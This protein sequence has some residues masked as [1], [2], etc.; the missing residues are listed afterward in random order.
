V[1]DSSRLVC[2]SVA[3]Q[4]PRVLV[5]DNEAS[6]R[7]SLA[8][9]LGAAGYE[10]EAAARADE[11]IDV[12]EEFAPHLVLADVELPDRDPLAAAIAE[13]GEPHAALV[14]LARREVVPAAIRGL[15]AGADGY[16]TK[17]VEEERLRFVA[18]RLIDDHRLRRR[19]D[20]MRVQLNGHPELRKLV[21][22]SPA[23]QAVR[24]GLAQAAESHA[25]VL[26]SGES[27]TGKHLAAEL[28]HQCRAPA[29][30]FVPA[31][32]AEMSPDEIARALEHAHQGTLFLDEVAD[33]PQA[34][35]DS[36]TEFLA[37]RHETGED[38]GAR[39]RWPSVQI[40]A[41][42]RHDL[43]SMVDTFQFSDEL[44]QLLR[45]VAL[46]MPPLRER[47]GDIPLLVDHFVRQSDDQTGGAR[48][49]VGRENMAW[50]MAHRWPGNVSE[51]KR[52]LHHAGSGLSR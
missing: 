25:P 17:P 8:A 26:L 32:C 12:L 28:L 44:L 30:R 38:T 5:A 45:G 4:P 36:L 18:E 13:H 27:G 33:L 40:A 51:L 22:E 42:T 50:L 24:A 35:Q 49:R 23:I 39:R 20:S 9:L 52:F 3:R 7:H 19:I 10:V 11:A 31:R 1:R 21:G 37:R 43:P 14:L 48:A 34:A 41:S 15:A 2:S 46:D 16:L 29:G 47:R 6:A